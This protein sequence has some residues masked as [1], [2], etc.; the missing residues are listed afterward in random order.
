ML[1]FVKTYLVIFYKN[2]NLKTIANNNNN[3]KRLL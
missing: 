2:F 3:I 1:D